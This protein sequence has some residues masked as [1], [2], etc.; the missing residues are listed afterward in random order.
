MLS[1]C[2]YNY[3]KYE[4]FLLEYLERH[5]IYFFNKEDIDKIINNKNFESFFQKNIKWSSILKSLIKKWNFWNLFRWIYFLKCTLNKYIIKKE[6]ML[7]KYLQILSNWKKIK[8]YFWWNTIIYRSWIAENIWTKYII[9]N[10]I[11]SW[12][13][14]IDW[15][16]YYFRKINKYFETIKRNSFYF[17]SINQTIIDYINSPW[18]IWYDF[19]KLIR[20]FRRNKEY[21][22]DKINQLYILNKDK[23][24]YKRFNYLLLQNWI[25]TKLEKSMKPQKTLYLEKNKHSLQKSLIKRK[26]NY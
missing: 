24:W 20:F 3:T 17:S 25:K 8:Y 2:K 18:F 9:Y 15:I 4:I 19:E 10:N 14:K 1:L 7:L 23:A 22:I 26:G 6:E 13:R 16:V 21:D 5:K 11:Y 12:T